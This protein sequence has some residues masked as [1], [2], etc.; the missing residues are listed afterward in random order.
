MRWSPTRQ[1]CKDDGNAPV[2]ADCNRCTG[3]YELQGNSLTLGLMAC[4][5]A[6]CLPGS[7]HDD[8]L[9][10][11]GSVSTWQ[12]TDSELLLMYDAGALRFQM[13]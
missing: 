1:A 11:L 2:R 13:Q 12:R 5:L 6:A 3:G 7:L 10:A 4:T 9:K 8:Y